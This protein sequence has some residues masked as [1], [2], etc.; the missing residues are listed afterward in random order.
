MAVPLL[1]IAVPEIGLRLAGNGHPTGFFLKK[2]IGGRP[3][4]IENGDFGLRFFPPELARTPSP[5][6]LPAD[7]GSN[8]YRIFVLGESAALGD[9][10][11]AFGFG[12]YLGALLGERYPGTRFE[13]ICTAMTAINSHVILPIAR[14]CAQHDGDLW[15]IYMGNNEFVGPFGPG[16]V[17]GA[18]TPGLGFIRASLALKQLRLVQWLEATARKSADRSAAPVSWGGM[19]MFLD[20]QVI[21]EDPRKPTV[22]GHFRQ[23]LEAI[24]DTAERAGVKVVVSTVGSNLKDCPPFASTNSAALTDSARNDWRRAFAAATNAA[25]NGNWVEAKNQFKAANR[26]DD[27]FAGSHF[28][29]GRC[30]LKL[31]DRAA[32]LRA[33]ELARDRDS[34]PFRADT[35]INRIIAEV[36]A[37]RSGAGLAVVDAA[38]ALNAASG[39]GVAGREFFHEHVHLNFEGNYLLARSVAESVVKLLPAAITSQASAA[40]WASFETCS[41]RLALSDWDRR[42]VYDNIAHRLMEPPFSNQP[43]RA[44]LSD[45]IRQDLAAVRQRL[46]PEATESARLLYQAALK[47]AA[48]DF[49]ILG[50]YAKFLEDIGELGAA[51]SAW[52]K[53]RDLLPFE[54]APHFYLGKIQAR[55][56]KTDAAMAS[57]SRALQIRP[58]ITEALQEK[59]RLLTE[60]RRPEEALALLQQA[61]IQQPRNARIHLQMAETYALQDRRELALNSLRRAVEAQPSLWEPHYL[62]GVELAA[63]NEIAE[64]RSQFGEAVRLRPEFALGRLNYGIALAKTGRISDAILQLEEAVRLDPANAKAAGYLQ[65]LRS[66]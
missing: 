49:L 12:R 21:P 28:G 22:Y 1:L 44:L 20:H 2:E 46:K 48:D 61:A 42:R 45:K 9:P 53:E 39:Q 27:T 40:P 41:R 36:G 34:L 25:A 47:T 37:R 66:R 5:V 14:D 35:E 56:R 65:T 58:D 62:L 52:E 54:A 17:F 26:L 33:L 29:E 63:G 7:K 23:N 18:Q 64:A 59:A 50:N 4:Y 38:A 3:V 43:D 24:L 55:Q 13:V 19:K 60:T 32:A 10:E 31:D 8:T 57:L 15:V 16:T 6:I 11:P 51:E 30:D